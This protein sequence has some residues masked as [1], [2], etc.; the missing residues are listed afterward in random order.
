MFLLFG[1]V[2]IYIF[3]KDETSLPCQVSSGERRFKEG[4]GLFLFGLGLGVGRRDVGSPRSNGLC[5][6]LVP[7]DCPSWKRCQNPSVLTAMEVAAGLQG[8]P[9]VLSRTDPSFAPRGSEEP[10][11]HLPCSGQPAGEEQPRASLLLSQQGRRESSSAG[12]APSAPL[13]SQ[14]RTAQVT[15]QNSGSFRGL[16]AKIY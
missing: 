5:L 16:T 11:E 15:T 12:L 4:E 8:S 1:V 3:N 2:Y 13:A 6:P 9:L 14:S 10:V 7:A